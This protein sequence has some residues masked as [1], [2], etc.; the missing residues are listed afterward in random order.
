MQQFF[1]PQGQTL[2]PIPG[3]IALIIHFKVNVIIFSS[4]EGTALWRSL[5]KKNPNKKTQ[6]AVT[7]LK[8]RLVLGQVGEK[9]SFKDI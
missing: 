3:K 2:V 8:Q 9:M 6:T 5:P 7:T 4:P 1:Q